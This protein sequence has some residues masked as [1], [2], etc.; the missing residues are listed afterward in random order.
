ME[1]TIID[2][3]HLLAIFYIPISIY[4]LIWLLREQ[5]N[6]RNTVYHVLAGFCLFSFHIGLLVGRANHCEYASVLS[7]TNL[8]YVAGCELTKPRFQDR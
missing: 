6:I 1:N 3:G 2:L 5:F 4:Y 7:R 8:P